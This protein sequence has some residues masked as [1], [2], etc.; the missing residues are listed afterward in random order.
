MIVKYEIEQFIKELEEKLPNLQGKQ[1][2][3]WLDKVAILNRVNYEFMDY[4]NLLRK[5]A[6]INSNCTSENYKLQ[7]RLEK[8]EKEIEH[9][10]ENING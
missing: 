4:E 3:Y 7:H 9:L 10:K 6:I 5:L 1:K 8:L 2:E